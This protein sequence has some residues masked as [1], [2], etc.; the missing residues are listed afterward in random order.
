MDDDIVVCR[1][2]K[3]R[4]ED[5]AYDYFRQREI[6]DAAESQRAFFAGK[7]ARRYGATAGMNPCRTDHETAAWARGWNEVDVE[8][9][10]RRA[11]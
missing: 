10:A 6:D 2:M 5:D 9:G 11:A 3:F 1:G 7:E 8:M 4:D